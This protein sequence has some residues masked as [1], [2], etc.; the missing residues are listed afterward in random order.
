MKILKR[1]GLSLAVIYGYFGL[2]ITTFTMINFN[3]TNFSVLI[4]MF[5]LMVVLPFMVYPFWWIGFAFVG[6]FITAYVFFEVC[7][8]KK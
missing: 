8:V 1:I 5:A 6:G 7:G 2:L 3:D 4:N